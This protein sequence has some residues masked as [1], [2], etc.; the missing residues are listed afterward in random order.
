MGEGSC[1][2]ELGRP[3]GCNSQGNL[4]YLPINI[5]LTSFPL[6]LLTFCVLFR[7]MD[8]RF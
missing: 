8:R 3:R 7:W 5:R 4:L 6:N 2:T 1:N